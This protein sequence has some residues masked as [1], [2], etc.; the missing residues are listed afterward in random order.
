MIASAEGLATWQPTS[1]NTRVVTVLIQIHSLVRWLVL[2]G[3]VSSVSAALPWWARA[4]R[5]RRVASVAAV[6][7]DVQVALGFVLWF[8]SEAWSSGVFFAA[9][10]PVAMLSALGVMHVTISAVRRAEEEAVTSRILMGSVLALVLVIAA[11]PW[12]R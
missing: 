11:I 9:V 2:A 5:S 1:L 7:L 6:L 10:H 3:L 12:A 4:E 8:G